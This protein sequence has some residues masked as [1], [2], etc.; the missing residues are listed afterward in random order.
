MSLEKYPLDSLAGARLAQ[1][2]S[3]PSP[4]LP[5]L[6][7]RAPTGPGWLFEPKLDGYR[8]LCKLKDGIATLLTRNGNDWSPRFSAIAE[9]ASNLPCKSAILDGEAVVFD[10]EGRSDF[11]ALQ[12]AISRQD[13]DIVLVAFDLL[14]LDGWDLSQVALRERKAILEELLSDAASPIRYGEHIEGRGTAFFQEACRAGL[15]GVLAKRA[16]AP[17]RSKRTRSWLKIKC[18]K[19]EEFVIV[20]FTEA[21]GLRPTFGALLLATRDAADESLRYVGKVG[22]GF[23]DKTLSSLY[24]L[25]Q[26]RVRPDPAFV[27]PSRSRAIANTHWIEP[28]LL[29]EVAFSGWTKNGQLR[30]ATFRGLRED[31]P[32]V[33]VVREEVSAIPVRK[34]STRDR[35]VRV[36]GIKI[37]NPDKLLFVEPAVSKLDLVHYYEQVAEVALP[38]LL[39]RPLT[40]LR[41][42]NGAHDDCFY[43]RHIP[44]RPPPGLATIAIRNESE[45]YL[46]V[47]G[48]SSLVTLA[49]LGVLELHVWGSRSEHLERPDIL[50]FDL[51]PDEDLPWAQVVDAAK[52]LRKRLQQ[53]DL[54]PFV[55]VT[56]GKGLHVVVPIVPG[57]GWDQVKVFTRAV[58][59]TMAQDE[60]SRFTAKMSKRSRRGKV[61]IDYLR[62]AWKATAIASYSPRARADAPVALPIEWEQLD[63]PATAPP[64]FSVLDVPELLARRVRD[65]WI[66]FE[67]TR[68]SLPI[69]S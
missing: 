35:T 9:A 68:G 53:L 21:S 40:L 49:Q 22:T 15:E 25:L 61:F 12:N 46:M 30:H 59:E 3:S 31:K 16:D 39:G 47:T 29:A 58:A 19:R 41:C 34:V 38:Y 60:P 45:P 42:P 8:L 52:S 13:S 11:Q 69:R 5:T 48:L 65:P 63:P 2:P 36:A 10:A 54:C 67:D 6:V 27:A 57:P 18:H 7:K 37:S 56:G 62:N 44:T 64:R 1:Q 24:P 50:V 20:G 66:E 4:Q 14:Y 23:D 17:Y 55:R 32:A 51:D 28:D 26:A 43:Q 33:E